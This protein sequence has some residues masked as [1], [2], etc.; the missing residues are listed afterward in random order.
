M[1]TNKSMENSTLFAGATVGDHGD[2]ILDRRL[3]LNPGEHVSLT[4]AKTAANVMVP[5]V[6]LHGT[7]LRYDSPFDLAIP[8]DDCEASNAC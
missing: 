1:T 8:D 5:A 3:P 4:I 6:D 7:V 2:L